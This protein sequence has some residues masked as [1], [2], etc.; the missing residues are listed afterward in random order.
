MEG[1]EWRG[2]VTRDQGPGTC[3]EVL[4]SVGYGGAG[5]Q[6]GIVLCRLI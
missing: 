1:G 6:E 5:V 3:R 4:V 2:V